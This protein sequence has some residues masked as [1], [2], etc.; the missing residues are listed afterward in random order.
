MAPGPELWQLLPAHRDVN[1]V[2]TGARVG[3]SAQ[4]PPPVPPLLPFSGPW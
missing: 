4:A 1:R 2:V 3:A